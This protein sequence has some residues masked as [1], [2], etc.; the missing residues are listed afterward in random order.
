MKYVNYL[1]GKGF[2]RIAIVGGSMGGAAVLKALE[3]N[4]DPAI[5]KVVLLAPAGN[6]GIGSPSISKYYIVAE[7]EGG[8][9]RVK[10]SYDQSSNPKKIKIFPGSAHAQHMFKEKYAEELKKEIID[11]L[12]N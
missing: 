11:F 3:T 6:I 8:F 12:I 7:N 1:K 5:K 4:I 9:T 10:Q 2:S